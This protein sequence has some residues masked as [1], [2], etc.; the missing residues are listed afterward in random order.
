MKGPSSEHNLN[1]SLRDY[2]LK[3]TNLGGDGI[4]VAFEVNYR[5]AL[6][7]KPLVVNLF[8]LQMLILIIVIAGRRR[9]TGPLSNL[10]AYWMLFVF[11]LLVAIRNSLNNLLDCAKIIFNL[12]KNSILSCDCWF[13]GFICDRFVEGNAQREYMLQIEFKGDYHL[14]FL[15]DSYPYINTFLEILLLIA[16]SSH[17][18]KCLIVF[19]DFVQLTK[20]QNI[21]KTIVAISTGDR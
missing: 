8:I 15:Q 4:D 14:I 2:S 19:T 5:K 20:A 11:V 18:S 1:V 21:T 16:L 9:R 17:I 6:L 12:F 13:D 3:F 7:S 10:S